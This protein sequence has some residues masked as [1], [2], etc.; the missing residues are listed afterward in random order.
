MIGL[1]SVAE[2]LA[3][4]LWFSAT[5]ITRP[6]VDEFSLSGAG[7]AWLT[8]AVQGGFVLGTL[9]SALMNLP[10]VLNARRLF[11]LGCALGAVAN[12]SIILVATG[13]EAILLRFVTGVALAWVYPPGMKIA[14][15]WVL[16]RRGTALGIIVGALTLGSASP[17]LLAAF[18]ADVSWQALLASASVAAIAAGMIVIAFVGD[19]PYV[20]ATARFDRHAA[21]RVFLDRG[22]RLATLGYLGHMWE[23][24][25][26]WTWIATFAAASLAAAQSGGSSNA[27]SLLAFV[28]IASGSIGC[29]AAGI[30]GDR[31]GKARIAGNAM[32]ASGACCALAGVLFGS[33][34][35]LLLLFLIW[36]G[37]TIVADSAQFSALVAEHSP[38]DRVGTALT[39]QTCAGFLLT[40]ISI[41]LTPLLAGAVGWRWAFA[42]LVPG[43]LLGWLAMRALARFPT[44]PAS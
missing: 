15:G 10:D 42:V 12:A 37:V 35:W 14:A 43:P 11:A 38:N 33:S 27:G 20:T 24:Y 21:A 3:M 16:H 1:V 25:A 40:M 31:W 17:H 36:W 26:M 44:A 23:L 41:R 22:T 39:V 30:Y 7:A 29:V 13:V 32:L 19:G 2:F 28:A 18:S 4:T 34:P 5:A 9:S 8:M 6:L